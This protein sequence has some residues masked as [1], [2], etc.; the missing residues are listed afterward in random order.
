M[1]WVR[2]RELSADGVSQREIARQLGMNRRTVARLAASREPPRY[3]R[4]PTG[5]ALDPLEPVMRRVLEEWPAIRAPR[6]TEILRGHGYAG[7][8]DQVKRRLRLLRGPQLRPLQRTAYAPGQTAQ[9]DWCEMPSRP[10]LLG[11]ERRVYALVLSLPHSG[12]Q[13]AHF[14]LD[15][16]ME[17]F[18]EGHVRAFDWL[19]GVP[20]EC[21]Y[22]NL[23][24]AVA[25]RHG[26][27]VEW[28]ARFVHLRGHYAF[29]AHACTPG[30]AWEKGAVEAAVRYL[31]SGFWP[32]RRI[33]SLA[34]LDRQYAEW[35]D[36]VANMRRHATGRF[37]VYERL[38]AERAALRPLPPVAFDAAGARPA[39]V[40]ADGYLRLGGSFYRAPARLVQQ[41]VE[42]R[43]DRDAVW[44]THKGVEVARYERSWEPGLWLPPPRA[45][46]EP[47]P[48]AAPAELAALSVPPP[49][50]APY[51]A[52]AS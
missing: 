48:L 26:T 9:L 42:L 16:T 19:G 6:M 23:R 27:S 33:A 46:P 2:V 5:S 36:G 37:L 1:E 11:R 32:A 22:D 10:R 51:A 25:R 34:D 44:I 8:V 13:T 15:T 24:T 29:H 45:R 41:R 18:L 7:S 52:L 35:R 43:H 31:K 40:P 21:V 38:A 47:P 49:E 17:S 14:T 50:L 30:A 4:E 28:A 20:R 12:A 39:R 3:R